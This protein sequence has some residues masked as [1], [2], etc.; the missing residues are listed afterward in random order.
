MVCFRVVNQAQLERLCEEKQIMTRKISDM[1]NDLK[2]QQ[3]KNA[4]VDKQLE[5]A[6]CKI[7]EVR[8]NFTSCL[9]CEQSNVFPQII[10]ANGL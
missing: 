10:G 2:I 9:N 4:S 8:E 5:D 7:K 3:Q 1:E 6:E